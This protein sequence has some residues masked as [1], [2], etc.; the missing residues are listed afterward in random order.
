MYIDGR[1]VFYQPV[2]IRLFYHGHMK[3]KIEIFQQIFPY[4]AKIRQIVQ[5]VRDTL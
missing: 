3:N 1:S 4:F 2:P 5:Q